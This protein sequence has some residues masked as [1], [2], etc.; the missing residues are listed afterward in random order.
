MTESPDIQISAF[1]DGELARDECEFLVRRLSRD[2]DARRKT[3]RYATIGAA[4]RGELIGPDPDVLRRRINASLEGVHVPEPVQAPVPSPHWRF[5]RPAAGVG[6]AASVA[7]AALLAVSTDR[8]IEPGADAPPV[9]VIETVPTIV[10]VETELLPSFVV[11]VSATSQ[12]SIRFTD[13][14]V[15]HNRFA[16]AIRR[17]SINSS[18][19][20]EQHTLRRVQELRTAE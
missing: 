5:V 17:A 14:L 15:Q 12:S 20:G 2:D 6:I 3:L 19:A 18:I 10:P 16:P 13:Y 4:L 7:I 9:A 1:A 11:P 8:D